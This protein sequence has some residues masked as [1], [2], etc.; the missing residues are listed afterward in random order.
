MCLLPLMKYD[1]KYTRLALATSNNWELSVD[2]LAT[3]WRLKS[4]RL[5]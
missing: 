3:I 2:P 5:S 1:R 4:S